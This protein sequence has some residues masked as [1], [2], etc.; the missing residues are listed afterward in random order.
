MLTRCVTGCYVTCLARR[1]LDWI[2]GRVGWGGQYLGENGRW[3]V[4]RLGEESV[5]Q[6]MPVEVLSLES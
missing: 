4:G 6:L 2:C 1:T 5:F 3:M